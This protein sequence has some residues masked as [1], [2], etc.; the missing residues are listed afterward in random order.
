MIEESLLKSN[1]IGRDGFRWW[2]GQIPPGEALGSQNKGGGWGNRFKVR[3]LGYHP[4]SKADLPDEDLPWAGCLLPATS[5]T[6]ASNL[7]QSVKYRPGDVVVGFFMDGDNAQIPMIMGAFGRTSQVPQMQPSEAFVPFTGYTTKVDSKEDNVDAGIG[8]PDGTL[9]PDE[10]NEQ[11]K[12]SQPSPTSLSKKQIQKVNA[13]SGSDKIPASKAEGTKI[14]VADSCDDN[15]LAEVS[16]VLDNFLSVIGE[17]VDFFT[18]IASVT[19]KLQTLTNNAVTTMMNSLYNTLIPMIGDGLDALW[20]FITVQSTTNF[21]KGIQMAQSMVLP[22]KAIQDQLECLPGKLIEGLGKTIRKMLE[23]TVMS[24]VNF[25]TCVVEQFAGDLLD[26]IIDQISG[27]LETV[28]GGITPILDY[29]SINV[30]DLLTSASDLFAAAAGFFD[31][32]Q[33]KSKCSGRVKQ[34]TIGYGAEGSFDLL[35]TYDK[36]LSNVNARNA[37]KLLN[38]DTPEN[39][40]SPYIKPDCA[41]VSACGGPTVEI[42]GGDGFGGAGKAILGGVVKNT[43]GLGD[44]TSNVTKTAS[45]IGVEITDPGSDYFYKE[46]LISFSDS[47]GLGYGA[48]AKATVDFNPNSPTYGQIKNVVMISEGE[49][50]PVVG[51]IEPPDDTEFIDNSPVPPDVPVGVI[52]VEVIAPGDGYVPGETIVIDDNGGGDTDDDGGDTT[53]YTVVIDD[54]QIVSVK[55]INITR[56]DR[57]PKLVATVGTGAILKPIIGRIPKA[58]PGQEIIQN[59]DCVT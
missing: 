58:P 45:I 13:A 49:N 31:C 50:Y 28:L 37:F 25:G 3:I 30:R 29:V 47:C 11:N 24:I 38:I 46:P 7:A 21:E 39:V 35:Q 18:D 14:T 15:F 55:P 17:G 57:L 4:Y 22:I 20:D 26:E 48:V 33:D 16:S 56:T 23:D 19:K 34:W 5:G 2:I 52:D 36:V 8:S 53:E 41:D 59:I 51:G 1:F 32:N 9:K 27:G 10:T 42:F 6:G 44:V 40:N 54:G 12:D 43:P